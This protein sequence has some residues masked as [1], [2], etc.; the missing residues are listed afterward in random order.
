MNVGL[1][2]LVG[3]S[4]VPADAVATGNEP[5]D[6][7]GNTLDRAIDRSEPQSPKPVSGDGS[8]ARSRPEGTGETAGTVEA[9]E[10]VADSG[11]EPTIDSAED[12]AE[13]PV[14]QV[15][16]VVEVV[17]QPTEMVEAPIVSEARAVTELRVEVSEEFSA[18]EEIAPEVSEISDDANA[19]S[20]APADVVDDMAAEVAQPSRVSDE[21][22]AEIGIPQANVMDPVIGLADLPAGLGED[23]QVASESRIVAVPDP[24][25]EAEVDGSDIP[26]DV[27][28][29]AGDDVIKPV[30]PQLGDP[31]GDET[32]KVS[33]PI[34][35]ATSA[36]A[37]GAMSGQGEAQGERQSTSSTAAA[38]AA[39][40]GRTS[41][42]STAAV[43]PAGSDDV[44]VSLVSPDVANP[45]GG[46]VG[47]PSTP[48]AGYVPDMA[49]V[50]RVIDTLGVMVRQPPPRTLTLDL[51]D[52]H[53]VRLT[54]S[55]TS[56]GGSLAVADTGA[57]DA[58]TE[59]WKQQLDQ[60]LSERGFGSDHRFRN[61]SGE[62]E[63]PE[64]GLTPRRAPRSVAPT[65][66]ELRL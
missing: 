37:G 27:I 2:V 31:D 63:P 23:D 46:T 13:E 53:G 43:A 35:R 9:D 41:I 66:N 16:V 1:L 36:T 47:T 44:T 7:F 55:V 24:G 19:D 18:V 3:P 26:A 10:P 39:D 60:L 61:R 34:S 28:V 51:T 52:M 58:N 21:V 8:R 56:S 33:D 50:N 32:V 22:V 40:T 15:V 20:G 64:R 30:G 6:A 17:R 57:G 48:A 42:G 12:A 29:P 49:A 65:S 54:I 62:D 59:Q 25:R 38:A 5:G 14:A 45:T 4:A 11:Q